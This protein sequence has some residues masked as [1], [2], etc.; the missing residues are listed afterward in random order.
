MRGQRRPFPHISLEGSE[1]QRTSLGGRG[2]G[3]GGRRE[4][5][6]AKKMESGRAEGRC[7][8]ARAWAAK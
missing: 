2:G 4:G 8:R 7:V 3:G 1:K 6:G 5:G